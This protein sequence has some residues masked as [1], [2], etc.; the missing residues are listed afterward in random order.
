MMDSEIK[1]TNVEAAI[2]RQLEY[3]CLDIFEINMKVGISKAYGKSETWHS[4]AIPAK[5]I[6]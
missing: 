3:P 4:A 6:E 5:V 2:P 1:G